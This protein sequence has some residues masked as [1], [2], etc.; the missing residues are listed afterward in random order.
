MSDQTAVRTPPVV[1]AEEWDAAR[2]D[3]LVSEKEL[4][5]ARDALAARRRR[6]PWLAVRRR[7]S[8]TGPTAG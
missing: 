3:L 1:T 8:S 5:R 2:Q 6:M 7:T 4:T